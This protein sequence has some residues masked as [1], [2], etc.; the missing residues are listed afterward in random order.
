MQVEHIF[1]IIYE[2]VEM[3]TIKSFYFI[4]LKVVKE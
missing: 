4:T 1:K 3:G 2:S